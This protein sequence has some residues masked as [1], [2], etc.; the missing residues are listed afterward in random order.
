MI[1]LKTS[2]EPLFAIYATESSYS[3]DEKDELFSLLQQQSSKLPRKS[4]KPF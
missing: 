1:Q 3:Q 2:P 4:K